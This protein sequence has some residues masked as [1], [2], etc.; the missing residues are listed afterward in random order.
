MKASKVT[1][2]LGVH[3]H[4]HLEA[5]IPGTTNTWGNDHCLGHVVQ[6]NLA[7]L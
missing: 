7:W 1:H 2:G 5:G 4:L 3:L 6:L